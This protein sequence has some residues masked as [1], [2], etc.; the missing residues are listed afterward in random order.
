MGNRKYSV[1]NLNIVAIS[2][3]ILGSTIGNVSHFQAQE[4]PNSNSD[5]Q[6][7]A[8]RDCPTWETFREAVRSG[9]ISLNIPIPNLPAG[10]RQGCVASSSGAH[11]LNVFVYREGIQ[12]KYKENAPT[13]NPIARILPPASG[14]ANKSTLSD[15]EI[16]AIHFGFDGGFSYTQLLDRYQAWQ[17]PYI[18]AG[19]TVLFRYTWATLLPDPQELPTSQAA[20]MLANVA[21][22][23]EQTRG[24]YDREAEAKFAEKQPDAVDRNCLAPVYRVKHRFDNV[25]GVQ[26]QR[27]KTAWIQDLYEEG[28]PTNKPKHV[29]V[30]IRGNQPE[31]VMQSGSK[32]QYAS[33]EILGECDDVGLLT[34]GVWGSGYYYRFGWVDGEIQAFRCR[35]PGLN[36][37]L[38]WGEQVCG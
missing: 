7:T 24:G 30:L 8:N 22:L 38:Q 3:A 25:S 34:V 32:L 28:V 5:N 17:E 2:L 19:G 35:Q 10:F 31:N 26:V 33:Q 9:K 27:S 12:P 20:P 6:Q 29:S 13:S 1:F 18:T 15:S 14:I 37:K 4:L 21:E 11:T 16:R 36:T 23:L